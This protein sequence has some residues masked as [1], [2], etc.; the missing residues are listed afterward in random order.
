MHGLGGGSKEPWQPLKGLILL[1]RNPP[2]PKNLE[3]LYT[4]DS[5]NKK[6]CFA[7]SLSFIIFHTLIKSGRQ[8]KCSFWHLKNQVADPYYKRASFI[9]FI[10]FGMGRSLQEVQLTSTL[11]WNM[12][13]ITHNFEIEMWQGNAQGTWDQVLIITARRTEHSPT[14]SSVWWPAD[15]N[16]QFPNER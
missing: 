16:V 3:P 2:K 11:L 4:G 5:E 14:P 8:L 12:I 9:T 1:Q 10:M 15:R 6:A 7:W 13:H